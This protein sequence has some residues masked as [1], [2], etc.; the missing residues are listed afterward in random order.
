ME[1]SIETRALTKRYGRACAIADLDLTIGTGV[2]G[3]LG[4][5]GAG[6]TTLLRILATSLAPTSGTVHVLGYDPG[7]ASGRLAIRRALG[8][9]PQEMGLYETFTVF[10]FVHYIAILKEHVD[11]RA[12]RAEVRRV[13]EAVDLGD[14]A[15]KRIRALSGG[16]R[17]RVALA[18]SLLGDPALLVLD[19]P[20]VGLDPEQRLRFRHTVS[21]HAERRC[22]VLSTHMTEDVEALCDRVVVM[23]QGRVVFDGTAASLAAIAAGGVWIAD[24][25]D[26]RA[27][28]SWRTGE[29][30]YRH[31]GEPPAG[32]ELIAPTVQD[33]Y[34]V[35]NGGVTD[36]VAA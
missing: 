12:R 28:V 20:T 14:V 34:L 22:V 5:N 6:K 19:E 21:Q 29:G 27:L 36:E 7:T 15:S 16:M 23:G 33:G 24:A 32:A 4:P 9:V 2:V 17:R 8:Y 26:A 18:Q 35:L 30:R 13:I 3:L 31:V 1:P 25:P 11:R 10:D